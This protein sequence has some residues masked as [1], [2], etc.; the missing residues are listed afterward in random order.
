MSLLNGSH[1]R[2]RA[3]HRV[4][5][6]AGSSRL[7]LQRATACTPAASRGE[8]ENCDGR[9]L[10]SSHLAGSFKMVV[11]MRKQQDSLVRWI[12]NGTQSYV[13][14]QI[15][16][17][18]IAFARIV[19]QGGAPVIAEVRIVP[20]SMADPWGADAPPPDWTESTLPLVPSGG[21]TSGHLKC[22]PL[23]RHL[24]NRAAYRGWSRSVPPSG[25]GYLTLVSPQGPPTIQ[26]AAGDL[27]LTGHVPTARIKPRPGRPPTPPRIFAELARDYEAACSS[28]RA[29]IKTLARRLKLPEHIVRNRVAKARELGFLTP[30]KAGKEGGFLTPKAKAV[31]SGRA[32]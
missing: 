2:Q 15:D 13:R 8:Y 19:P 29:P 11:A 18:W 28:R 23:H 5:A 1:I 3:G 27:S 32:G 7:K 10:Y 16:P 17:D 20:T 12:T 4:L 25:A 26:P 14:T 31:L 30:G 22:W 6:R 21:L 9:F 24:G